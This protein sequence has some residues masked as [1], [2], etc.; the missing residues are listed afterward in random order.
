[1]LSLLLLAATAPIIAGIRDEMPSPALWMEHHRHHVYQKYSQPIHPSP[2]L[3]SLD[4]TRPSHSRRSLIPVP[5]GLTDRR[6]TSAFLLLRGG[7]SNTPNIYDSDDEYEYDDEEDEIDLAQED[8][9]TSMHQKRRDL[10]DNLNKESP[11]DDRVPR[12]PAPYIPRKKKKKKKN[13]FVELAKSSL[14]LSKKAAVTTVQTS[15]KA[16]YYLMRPKS[17]SEREILGVWRLDQQVGMKQSTAN[18][19]LTSRGQVIIRSGDDE[20]IIWKAPF[21]FVAPTWPQSCRVE[22]EA[23]AFQPAGSKKPRLFF[24][25]G[26][27]ERKMADSSVIK[28]SGIL[29]EIERPKSMFG[30]K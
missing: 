27:L 20:T 30:R 17:I 8:E 19:E 24:Y 9:A 12:R 13:A 26:Y 25:K 7:G 3:I 6:P 11:Y 10:R 4:P 14:N 18:I 15:G 2:L 29:Y 23:R 28:M 22:F 21:S 16:A 1:M 5:F